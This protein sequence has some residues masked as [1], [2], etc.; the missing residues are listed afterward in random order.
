MKRDIATYVVDSFVDYKGETR[1]FVAC[2]LSQSPATNQLKI[3]WINDNYTIDTSDCLYHTVYRMVTIGISVCNPSDVFDLELGKRI[4]YNK[5]AKI[6]TLPRIYTT[7]KGIITTD[8]VDA[9]LKQQI[10]FFKENP[11]MFIPGYN[12]SKKEYLEKESVRKSISKLSN[13]EKIA[14]NLAIKGI[15]LQK[16]QDLAKFYLRK[17]YKHD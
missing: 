7:D 14:F 4:A 17:L 5:A 15:K 16:Y 6:E 8:L 1:K 11:E 3:G 9:F 13:D 10:K 12:E 2:A